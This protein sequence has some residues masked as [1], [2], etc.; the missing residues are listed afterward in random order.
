M[1]HDLSLSLTFCINLFISFS[2]RVSFPPL[3]ST[4]HHITQRLHYDSCDFFTHGACTLCTILYSTVLY[5]EFRNILSLQPSKCPIVL[6][7]GELQALG[8][9]GEGSESMKLIA[10]IV[11][12][13]RWFSSPTV[14]VPEPETQLA[15][16]LLCRQVCLRSS[17]SSSTTTH[18]I[19]LTHPQDGIN[20]TDIAC[21]K[22]T[23]SSTWTGDAREHEPNPTASI[24]IPIRPESFAVPTQSARVQRIPVFLSSSRIVLGSQRRGARLE[25]RFLIV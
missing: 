17:L 1:Y 3:L 13:W 19:V 2:Y 8:T 12:A 5:N 9:A 7:P 16:T 6:L 11:C 10:E 18:F 24:S 25:Q 4:M 21:C 22:S 23:E 15:P 14:P 20:R